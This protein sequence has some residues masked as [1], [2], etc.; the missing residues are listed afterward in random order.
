MGSAGRCGKKVDFSFEED[1]DILDITTNPGHPKKG[2]PW[3][4]WEDVLKTANFG[5][6]T[7]GQLQTRYKTIKRATKDRT[8]TGGETLLDVGPPVR[9]DFSFDEDVDIL[10]ITTNP[11]YPKRGVP[12][13][14]WEDVVKTVN[15]GDKTGGQLQTR[16]KCIRRK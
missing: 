2:V 7:V 12:W 4:V 9:V 3:S 15:F 5:D 13:S 10:D 11:G 6:K 1:I 8:D 14:V 16:Y